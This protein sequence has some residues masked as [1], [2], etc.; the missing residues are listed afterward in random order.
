MEP[1]LLQPDEPHA[2]DEKDVAIF[3]RRHILGS[4]PRASNTPEIQPNPL[5]MVARYNL[6]YHFSLRFTR[7][8]GKKREHSIH[9]LII[10]YRE[11]WYADT[12][13]H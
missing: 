7:R 3:C 11:A 1:D 13:A 6:I 4:Y 12:D 5:T 10:S 8:N 2:A 9:V